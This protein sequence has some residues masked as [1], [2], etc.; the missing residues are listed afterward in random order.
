VQYVFLWASVAPN[1][2]AA[3]GGYT[4]A[5]PLY[6]LLFIALNPRSQSA[7]LGHRASTVNCHKQL[8]EFI[9]NAFSNT[10]LLFNKN[11]MDFLV[12]KMKGLT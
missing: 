5:T 9:R 1:S 4:P 3:S 7:L 8:V 6:R 2:R 10:C 12:I 11:M